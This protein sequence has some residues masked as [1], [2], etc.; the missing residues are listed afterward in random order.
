MPT[1]PGQLLVSVPVAELRKRPAHAAEL[2]TQTLLG[3]ALRASGLSA[4]GKWFRVRRWDGYAGWIRSWSVTPLPAG[5][6]RAL[7][8]GQGVQIVSRRAP[9]MKRPG[10]GGKAVLELPFGARLAGPAGRESAAGWVRLV[11][12][13]GRAGWLDEKCLAAV[14]RR[15]RGP[16]G[17]A[18]TGRR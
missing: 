16:G 14:P 9:L 8:D 15:P 18:S 7:E 5:A 6:P 3:E 10:P 12:P 17:P 13:D 4:D 11:L 1:P 2:L